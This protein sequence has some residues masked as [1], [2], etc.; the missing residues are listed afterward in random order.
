MVAVGH[1]E[2]ALWWV[3]GDDEILFRGQNA[4]ILARPDVEA[5][6]LAVVGGRQRQ[7]LHA[8]H[9]RRRGHQIHRQ[10]DV[11]QHHT[12]HPIQ[13]TVRINVSLQSSIELSWNHFGS[14]GVGY[15][16]MSFT[17]L[18]FISP[19]PQVTESLTKSSSSS[20]INFISSVLLIIPKLKLLRAYQSFNESPVGL[21]SQHWFHRSQ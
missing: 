8:H 18:G 15:L 5:P 3:S 14:G 7:R 10:V 12:D 17:S 21:V 13:T 9:V 19:Q 11:L 2:D 20:W 1:V 16:L 4:Q 6:H